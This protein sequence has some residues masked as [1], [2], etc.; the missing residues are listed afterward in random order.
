MKKIHNFRNSDMSILPNLKFVC[1]RQLFN[2][3]IH[4]AELQ[5]FRK[6]SNILSYLSKKA[7]TIKIITN[8]IVKKIWQML[9]IK[10]I[11]I[12][13]I[14]SLKLCYANTVTIVF[15]KKYKWSSVRMDRKF[16]MVSYWVGIMMKKIMQ[17]I[18]SV[19]FSMS[20]GKK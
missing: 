1:I 3:T 5:K 12:T 10:F 13:R 6:H 17:N 9:V 19:L 16:L 2:C 8:K 4:I 7:E 20:Y 11:S 18:L 15:R 14:S